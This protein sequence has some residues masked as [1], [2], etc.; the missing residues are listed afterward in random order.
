MDTLLA[1]VL[2]ELRVLG[3]DRHGLLV[4]F[5]MPAIF[6]CIMSLVLRAPIAEHNDTLQ[7]VLVIDH[8]GG[9]L[10]K[11]LLAQMR[12]VGKLRPTLLTGADA[13]AE[14]QRRLRAGTPQF[15]LLI[16]ADFGRRVESSIGDVHAKP[17]TAGLVTL[18]YAP[19]AL[20]QA[21]ALFR[22]SVT[23]LLAS[24]EGRQLVARLLGGP[25]GTSGGMLHIPVTEVVAGHGVEARMPNAV[26]QSVPAWLVFAMFFVVIPLSTALIVERQQGSLLRL[27]SLGIPALTVMLARVPP[28][29][30]INLGQMLA[31]LAVG[32]WV[33]PLLGGNTLNL[34]HAPF[35][36]FLIGS[37]TSFAAIGFALLIAAIAR[38]SIQ[39]TTFGGVANLAL[40]AIGGVMVPT[41]VMTPF[42]QQ[43]AGFS[44]MAWALNGFLDIILRDES[45]TAVLPDA[46]KLTLFG[47]ICLLL[48]A[49]SMRR[50]DR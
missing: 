50:A 13:A 17:D 24:L 33:V 40:G 32:V 12:A 5:L 19:T 39:A 27:R 30:L 4:L 9:P 3:R 23:A 47:L 44:P 20:P 34:G 35:G 36:L 31:M 2:K 15:G 38:T 10:A 18:Y 26:Q 45:W 42:M 1:L 14:L 49:A 22:V 25:P 8:D 46:G 6:I 41:A 48:A 11:T 43:V 7:S 29:Y 37:A 28:Y 21:R 16:P